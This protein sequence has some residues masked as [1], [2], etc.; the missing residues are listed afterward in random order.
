MNGHVKVLT[1]TASPVRLH[2]MARDCK[3]LHEIVNIASVTFHEERTT[4]RAVG[5]VAADYSLGE[6]FLYGVICGAY[7]G[8]TPGIR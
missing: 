2:L 6:Y 4:F 7:V 1:T 8:R 5:I 3:S